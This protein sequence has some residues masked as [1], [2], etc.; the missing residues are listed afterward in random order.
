[1]S[2]LALVLV[3]LEIAELGDARL[4]GGHVLLELEERVVHGVVVRVRRRQRE[5][6]SGRGSPGLPTVHHASSSWYPR[7]GAGA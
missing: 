4:F 6:G 1:M 2:F 7:L 5:H 3:A